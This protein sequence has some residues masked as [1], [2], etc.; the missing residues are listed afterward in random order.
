MLRSLFQPGG[1]TDASR[2]RA[3]LLTNFWGHR[4]QFPASAPNNYVWCPRKST[5]R[6]T[7]LEPTTSG[8]TE[9]LLMAS[10]PH[11]SDCHLPN[12]NSG[13]SDCKTFQTRSASCLDL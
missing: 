12:C 11:L 3:E 8:V 7:G 9:A 5:A 6:M 13:L 4:T 1:A 2:G 10:Q